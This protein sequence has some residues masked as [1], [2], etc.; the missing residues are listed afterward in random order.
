[1]DELGWEW[2]HW[3]SQTGGPEIIATVEVVFAAEVVCDE[4]GPEPNETKRMVAVG[5]VGAVEA[6]GAWL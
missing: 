1:V 4:I 3:F 6:A 2:E 5:A